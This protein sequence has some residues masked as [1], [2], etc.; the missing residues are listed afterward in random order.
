MYSLKSYNIKHYKLKIK[1]N[2]VNTY[3]TSIINKYL[4]T[5]PFFHTK[6]DNQ[7]MMKGRECGTCTLL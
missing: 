5:I 3:N 1:I 6:K 2:L 4:L 7:V